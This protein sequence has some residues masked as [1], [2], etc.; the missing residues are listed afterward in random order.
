MIQLILSRIAQSILIILAMTII[1]FVGLNAVGN[2]VD[3]LIAPNA[4]QAERLRAIRALGLDQPL[5]KQYLLFLGNAMQ[6]NLGLSF[7]SGEPALQLILSRLPATIEL[8][9]IAVF[10]ALV[11]GVPIGMLAG[12]Y[13]KSWL[14]RAIMGFSVVGFSLPAFWV[15]LMLI[16]VFAVQLG[17]LPSSGRGETVSL[18]G[19]QVSFLTVDG[20][21]HLILPAISLGLYKFCLVVRLVRAGVM[22]VSQMEYVKFA[23]AKGLRMRRVIFLHM[24][25][26]I[27]IPVVT[28]VGLELGGTIAFAVVTESIFAWPGVGRLIIQSIGVLDRPVII[29][30]LMIVVVLFVVLNL[31]TDLAYAALDPRVRGRTA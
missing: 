8:A 25:K 21:R 15:A 23:R 3:T 17:W 31:L 28:V 20:I 16:I 27:M 30:Y 2:P 11:I 1:V 6:G 29:A 10:S 18:L 12:V 14:S 13:P 19:I 7:V 5:W 22:E 4:G 24:L 9:V 26:N